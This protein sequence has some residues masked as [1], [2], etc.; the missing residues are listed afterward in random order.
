MD[1]QATPIETIGRPMYEGEDPSAF[2]PDALPQVI[3][4]LLEAASDLA[5]HTNE[6]EETLA[7]IMRS[8]PVDVAA[9]QLPVLSEKA[10]PIAKP[11]HEVL[12]RVHI[13]NQMLQV[14]RARADVQNLPQVAKAAGVRP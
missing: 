7:P 6:L 2:P 9:R 8:E 3:T 4:A 5:H 11:L 1:E 14:M 13:V 10:A 12:E